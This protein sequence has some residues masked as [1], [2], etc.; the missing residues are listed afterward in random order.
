[1]KPERRLERLFLFF[2]IGE[3]ANRRN[4][5]PRI[6]FLGPY[7]HLPVGFDAPHSYL[8]ITSLGPQPIRIWS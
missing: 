6:S 5:L 8:T 4:V 2:K 7:E 3:N 1:M